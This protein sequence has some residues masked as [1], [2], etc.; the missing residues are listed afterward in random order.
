MILQILCI[1]SQWSKSCKISH[2]IDE[3]F[4]NNFWKTEAWNK[5]FEN[6]SKFSQQPRSMCPELKTLKFD[7]T[8]PDRL[9]WIS[10]VDTFNFFLNP[11]LNGAQSFNFSGLSDWLFWFLQTPLYWLSYTHFCWYK[12][13]RSSNVSIFTILKFSVLGIWEYGNVTG[14]WVHINH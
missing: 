2:K 4:A 13:R 10:N 9:I 1:C 7:I 5:Y 11:L 3:N 14:S 6:W 8:N 12:K